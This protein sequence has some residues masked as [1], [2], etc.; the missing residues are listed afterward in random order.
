[1]TKAPRLTGKQVIAA[2]QNAGFEVLRIKGSHT[3]CSILTV[4]AQL[5]QSTRAKSSA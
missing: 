2:L 1:M 3:L 5:S 4:D